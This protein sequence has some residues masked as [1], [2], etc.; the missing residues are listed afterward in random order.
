MKRHLDQLLHLKVLKAE[1]DIDG[2]TTRYFPDPKFEKLI[3][4]DFVL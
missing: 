2:K 1:K 4:K 3:L